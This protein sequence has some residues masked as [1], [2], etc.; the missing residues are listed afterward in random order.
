[1]YALKR[2]VQFPGYQYQFRIKLDFSYEHYSL[3]D[4]STKE[5]LFYNPTIK[6]YVVGI[7]N[8]PILADM[9][10]SF[11]MRL[12]REMTLYKTGRLPMPELTLLYDRIISS[13]LST[14]YRLVYS[15]AYEVQYKSPVANESTIKVLERIGALLE[16]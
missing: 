10:I 5:P 13:N 12:D 1:M 6:A 8:D 11:L 4:I 14:I 3:T 9:Q 15:K 2:L 7:K 16:K